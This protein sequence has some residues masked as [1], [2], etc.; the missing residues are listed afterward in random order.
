M[1]VESMTR[2]NEIDRMLRGLYNVRDHLNNIDAAEVKSI[3][4]INGRANPDVKL[5][6]HANEG[7]LRLLKLGVAARITF[8]EKEFEA[9]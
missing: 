5:S 9:L 8:L 3:R 4:V 7:V 1:T 6:D 2:G